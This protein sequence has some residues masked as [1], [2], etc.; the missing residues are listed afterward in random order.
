MYSFG[1][2]VV[3]KWVILGIL[4]ITSDFLA[5]LGPK[6][7]AMAQPTRAWGPLNY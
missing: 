2:V 1:H 5:Q 6:A 7:R 3:P 4:V